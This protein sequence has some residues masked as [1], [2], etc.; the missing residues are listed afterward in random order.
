MDDDDEEANRM[1][2]AIKAKAKDILHIAGDP[3]TKRSFLLENFAGML[4]IAVR[5]GGKVLAKCSMTGTQYIIKLVQINPD[6]GMTPP[7]PPPVELRLEPTLIDPGLLG[8]EH[9]RR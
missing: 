3:S 7:T 9:L 4:A 1:D 2:Q 6:V 5:N 8:R